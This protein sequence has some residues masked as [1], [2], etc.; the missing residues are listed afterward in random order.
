MTNSNMSTKINNQVA[1]GLASGLD[2]DP[3]G[4]WVIIAR[5]REVYGLDGPQLVG[6]TRT[7]LSALMAVG[8]R[9]IV[10]NGENRGIW[11]EQK[12]Y[13]TSIEEIVD[14]VVR[15]WQDSG[16]DPDYGLWFGLPKFFE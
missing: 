8:A 12:Q 1:Q 13:G 10:G 16:T 6:F 9:P 4:F 11:I 7:C 2:I 14:N 3:V 15:E 5:G